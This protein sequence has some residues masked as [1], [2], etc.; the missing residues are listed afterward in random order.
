M[1]LFHENK[2]SYDED[3]VDWKNILLQLKISNKVNPLPTYKVSSFKLAIQV[4]SL[5]IIMKKKN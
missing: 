5:T 2:F 3:S 1:D 4:F